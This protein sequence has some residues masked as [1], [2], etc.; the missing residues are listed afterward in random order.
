M[1]TLVAKGLCNVIHGVSTGHS[2]PGTLRY[3]KNKGT[4]EFRTE[5]EQQYSVNWWSMHG[6][7]AL[8]L[9]RVFLFTPELSDTSYFHTVF[10]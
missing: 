7:I 3:E 2:S 8:V 9:R 10:P 1:Q 5:V 6:T 4:W